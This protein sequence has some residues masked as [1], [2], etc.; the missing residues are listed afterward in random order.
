MKLQIHFYWQL[1]KLENNKVIKS[2][3]KLNKLNKEKKEKEKDKNLL[4][5]I[6]KMNIS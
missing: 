3:L 1:V 4:N 2:K 6:S 5:L